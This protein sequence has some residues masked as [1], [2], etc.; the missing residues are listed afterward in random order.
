MSHQRFRHDPQHRRRVRGGSSCFINAPPPPLPQSVLDCGLLPIPSTFLFTAWSR[1][2]QDHRPS[3]TSPQPQFPSASPRVNSRLY[4]SPH[5]SPSHARR[6]RVS[7]GFTSLCLTRA[8]SHT[9]RR[10]P[11]SSS[12]C[13]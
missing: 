11:L 9:R 1:V 10:Q 12:S 13:T 8:P 4:S 6:I 7:P 5:P 2:P 3:L